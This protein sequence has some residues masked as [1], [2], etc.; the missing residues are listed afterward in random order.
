MIKILK[1]LT[2]YSDGGSRGNPGPAAIAFVMLSDDGC[3]QKKYSHFIG[4]H[5]NNQSEYKALIAALKFASNK[6]EEVTCYLD[7]ELVVKQLNGE[8][9]V[10]NNQLRLLWREVQELKKIFK[11]TIFINVPRTNIHLQKADTLLNI[12]LDEYLN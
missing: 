5:T 4:I 1:H 10:K 3:I 9:S 12:K 8:Y 11:K 2:F 6:S 7:S